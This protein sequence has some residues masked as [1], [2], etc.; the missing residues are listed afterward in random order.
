MKEVSS[1]QITNV[2]TVA[3]VE[4]NLRAALN[5]FI[6]DAVCARSF[7]CKTSTSW[8]NY[9]AREHN[10]YHSLL[11]DVTLMATYPRVVEALIDRHSFR[12]N[13]L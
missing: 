5:S 11:F 6:F 2:H 4:A 10:N 8:C 12:R 1:L 9:I 7:L 13:H 3:T